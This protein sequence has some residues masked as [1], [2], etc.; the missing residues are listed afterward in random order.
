MKTGK[1]STGHL[2]HVF[3]SAGKWLLDIVKDYSQEGK[4]CSESNSSSGCNV[5]CSEVRRTGFESSILPDALGRVPF[6]PK[7]KRRHGD[8]G[9][10]QMHVSGIRTASMQL[11]EA[12]SHLP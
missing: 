7:L 11:M 4:S 3:I 2:Q 6:S 1:P 9:A 12:V 10:D 8:R 5:S